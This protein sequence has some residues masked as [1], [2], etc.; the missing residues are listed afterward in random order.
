MTL[1]SQALLTKSGICGK[2]C[3]I[4]EDK[5]KYSMEEL[6]RSK[7]ELA[8]LYEIGTAMHTTLKLDQILFIILTGVTSH[9]G[10]SFNRAMLFLVN[11][12]DNTLEGKMGIGPDTA[13]EA[14]KVWS[15]IE[16][17]KMTLEDLINSYDNWIKRS[18]S[19]LNK[20]VKSIKIPLKE[21][22]GI[23]AMA[24]LE[25]MSFE[26]TNQETRSKVKSH[27]LELLRAEYFV[28]VPLMSKDKAIGVIM[29]DNI[30]TR[31][32]ISKDDIRVLTMFADQ[33]G[34]AIEN[35]RLYEK[36]LIMSH[37]DSLTNLWNHGYFHDMLTE[38]LK[39]SAANKE[40]LSLAML[41]FDN[42]KIYNDTLGHQVGD[43]ALKELASILRKNI[44]END[45]A[46]RYGGEEF[47]IILPQKN[48]DEAFSV[49]ERI[50]K[51]IEEYA[52]PQK[53]QLPINGL[54]VSIG[55]ATFPESAKTKD[56]LIS[57]ADA[58]LYESKRRGKNRSWCSYP[59]YFV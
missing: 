2:I 45:Y 47:A 54:T 35:S 13:E 31:K 27:I 8:I 9:E 55:I 16:R 11:E 3:S 42:F 18:P 41:D 20:I 21:E 7:S 14:G 58:A 56:E 59:K 33:A 10:L 34:M 53:Q 28:I 36:T 43:I 49:A 52:F 46:C 15:E 29:A 4:M 37:T 12:N 17:E 5:A 25:G 24:A 39:K 50:R 48:T 1:G 40:K 6:A 23:L 44:R 19:E 26:V 22:S 51:E 32:P 57:A 30:F 38:E